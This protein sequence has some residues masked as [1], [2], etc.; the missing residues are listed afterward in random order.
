MPSTHMTS[1]KLRREEQLP[2]VAIPIT[3]SIALAAARIATSIATTITPRAVAPSLISTIVP[4]ASATRRLSPPAAVT[5]TTITVLTASITTTAATSAR[6]T[7]AVSIASTVTSTRTSSSFTSAIIRVIILTATSFSTLAL[8]G[9]FFFL[10][11]R[12]FF[13][14]LL[15][16]LRFG[17]RLC[18]TSG[19]DVKLLSEETD[20]VFT[21]HLASCATCGWKLFS[22]SLCI[23]EVRQVAPHELQHLMELCSLVASNTHQRL[24]GGGTI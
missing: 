19:R 5:L 6:P 4:F 2:V 21:R 1:C 8:A 18:E 7:A 23:I 9:R 10:S 15:R 22:Q 16:L 24:K 12:L 11:L 20:N 14:L 17:A 3:A 13:L